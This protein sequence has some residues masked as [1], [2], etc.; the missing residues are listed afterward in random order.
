MKE[1]NEVVS[2]IPSEYKPISM[3]IYFGYEILFSLPLIGWIILF[4]KALSAKNLNLK[5][6][7]RSHFCLL[8]IVLFT[9]T[10]SVA[11]GL[12]DFLSTEILRA[13]YQ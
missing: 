3:W 9:V 12:I 11:L 13:L 8:L 4:K 5:N 1:E 2:K 10:F 6:F 7:A